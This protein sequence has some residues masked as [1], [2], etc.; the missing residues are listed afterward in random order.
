MNPTNDQNLK[1]WLPVLSE[2]DFPIQSLPYGI[3][4]RQRGSEA[5]GQRVCV[6][7]W[8]V[9]LALASWHVVGCCV[10]PPVGVVRGGRTCRLRGGGWTNCGEGTAA[11]GKVVQQ[12]PLFGNDEG[13]AVSSNEE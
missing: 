8:E 4:R 7:S 2:S 13:L 12:L 10:R 5:T 3:C 9:L 1:S 11:V 6:A